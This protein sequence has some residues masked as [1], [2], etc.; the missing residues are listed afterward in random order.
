MKTLKFSYLLV[1]MTFLFL[2]SCGSDDEGGGA[3]NITC[4]SGQIVS[5]NCDCVPDPNAIVCN[6]LTC[7]SGQTLNE[8]DCVCACTLTCPTGQV[9]NEEDC[10]CEIDT[11]GLTTLIVDMSFEQ[12]FSDASGNNLN[13]TGAGTIDFVFDNDLGRNVAEFAEDGYVK[14]PLDEKLNFG[15]DKDFTFSVWVKTSTTINSDPAIISSQDW[16]AGSNPGFGIYL[17]DDDDK[18][19]GVREYWKFKSSGGTLDMDGHDIVTNGWGPGFET[20]V[21]GAWTMLTIT[22]DRDGNVTAYQDG[23]QR[24]QTTF[25]EGGDPAAAFIGDLNSPNPWVIMQHGAVED[26][27]VGPYDKDFAG[28]IANVKIY[29]GVLT[30]AE[31]GSL[32]AEETT[33]GTGGSGI[34]VDMSFEQDLNDASGNGLNGTGVGTVDIVFDDDLGRNVA[35]FAEDGYVKLPIDEKL[36][37]GTDKDF[38]FSI[39]VKTSTTINSDPAIISSQDWNAGSNPGFGIY[40]Q[41]DDDKGGG[42]REYWKFKSSGG[43]LDMDGHDI[44]INGWGEGFETVVD[45]AWTMLTITADRDGNVTAYQDGI[46]RGQTTFTEGGD[47]AAAF[48][49][50]LTSPNPW[51]IMQHGG[52]EDPAVGPYDKD[53]SGRI[54]DV[55]IYDRV[56]TASEVANLFPF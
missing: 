55:K 15:T 42:V 45:G 4:P 47:P 20:V 22:A 52:V 44:V 12:D 43:T 31:V 48:I 46:Q 1:A 5:A 18:G 51:V 39:L 56:L 25:T 14:L 26:I 34:V 24:G 36:N 50:D 37:F 27:A 35:E 32:F 28:R 11:T 53:F 41:D 23:I 19:G 6:G 3:C 17:Q 33:N 21:D 29:E 38:T 7:P 13:G 10:A 49:G 54:A 30:S 2:G 16:N 40:L 9:L 8:Q